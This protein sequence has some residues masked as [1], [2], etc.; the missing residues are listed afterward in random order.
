MQWHFD[1]GPGPGA[2]GLQS[3]W[4]FGFK[5]H[6]FNV[7]NDGGRSIEQPANRAAVG[8]V[9]AAMP[10]GFGKTINI[11]TVRP[12]LTALPEQCRCTAPRRASGQ[13][14]ARYSEGAPAGKT[15]PGARRSE[16]RL[17]A[18]QRPVFAKTY[19]IPGKYEPLFIG[20]E[21]AS[22]CRCMGGMMKDRRERQVVPARPAV[23]RLTGV[24]VAK[25]VFHIATV[26]CLYIPDELLEDV[27]ASGITH[28]A[29]VRRY[30]DPLVPAER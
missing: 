9:Q 5:T 17:A 29:D 25:H 2:Q 24:G 15:S 4:T 6:L 10:C 22:Q 28:L 30:N 16:Q 3:H 21:L 19:A 14:G 1:R 18:P 27:H 23:R 20:N 8:T 11:R 26:K 12:R 7:A 13:I